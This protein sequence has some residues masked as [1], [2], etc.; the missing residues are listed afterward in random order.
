MPVQHE[1]KRENG[2]GV[3][4]PP[5]LVTPSH[6]LQRSDEPN[7]FGFDEDELYDPDWDAAS[8]A[9]LQAYIHVSLKD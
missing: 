4:E 7:D 9:D 5:S 2:R 1:T 3:R 6:A 8:D